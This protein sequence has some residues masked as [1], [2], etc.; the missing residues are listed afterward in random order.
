[1]TTKTVSL[2]ATTPDLLAP[3]RT[4]SILYSASKF[5]KS[6][7]LAKIPNAYIIDTEKGMR[8]YKEDIVKSNSCVLETTDIEEIREEI[9]KL[10][11]H[12]H[13]FTT[14]IIDSLSYLYDLC[15]DKWLNIHKRY[16]EEEIK[17]AKVDWLKNKKLKE[18]ELNDVGYKYWGNLN[19]EMRKLQYLLGSKSEIDMNVIIVTYEQ[20]NE[21]EDKR[22]KIAEQII[23]PYLPK[24]SEYIYDYCIRL[25]KVK[26]DNKTQEGYTP[27][28]ANVIGKGRP[29]PDFVWN[30]EN[31]QKYILRDTTSSKPKETADKE[32]IKYI[33]QNKEQCVSYELEHRW[34]A[35]L[36][37]TDWDQLPKEEGKKIKEYI[38]KK[39]VEQKNTAQQKKEEYDKF[40]KEDIDM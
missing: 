23:R 8:Y 18:F 13:Q 17:S 14:L 32:T 28:Y 6:P 3:L 39:L 36:D 27:S 16:I 7:V 24:K 1:M 21:V 5:G 35:K 9:I 31:L 19:G 4:K 29:I 37:I 33:K 20:I 30:F 2:K 10:Q 34:L 26:S 15:S 40:A 25:Y 12:S 38:E 22:T 11:T